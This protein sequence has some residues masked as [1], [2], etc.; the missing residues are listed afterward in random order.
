[1]T[2]TPKLAFTLDP[3]SLSLLRQVL[4]N[5]DQ[6]R[7][8]RLQLSALRS[9]KKALAEADRKMRRI[10]AATLLAE[11]SGCAILRD[12]KTSAVMVHDMDN[13]LLFE[14]TPFT[15]VPDAAELADFLGSGT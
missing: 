6:A 9:T 4:R 5:P 7:L 13:G 11:M 2:T 12:A 15:E 8:G 3:A 10:E 1:M 14:E